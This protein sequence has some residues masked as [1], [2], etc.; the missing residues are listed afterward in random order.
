MDSE[1]LMGIEGVD[2]FP[3]DGGYLYRERRRVG[4]ELESLAAERVDQSEW[5]ITRRAEAR[6]T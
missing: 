2:E 5:V 3:W 1:R 6:V 4:R